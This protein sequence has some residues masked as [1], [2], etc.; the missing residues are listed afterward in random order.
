VN[1][2]SVEQSV[3]CIFAINTG[4]SS[5]DNVLVLKAIKV[6]SVKSPYAVDTA[7]LSLTGNANAV[8]ALLAQPAIHT[9]VGVGE[10]ALQV[11][12][13]AT[14]CT[15]DQGAQPIAALSAVRWTLV[16]AVLVIQGSQAVD[17]TL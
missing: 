12:A 16:A 6:H 8:T 3:K 2:D 11:N 9:C 10:S 5:G 1:L 7:H 15:A 13:Y 17:V 4:L 14:K